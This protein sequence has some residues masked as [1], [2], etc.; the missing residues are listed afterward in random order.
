MNCKV[1]GKSQFLYDLK[2]E[3]DEE[4]PEA[5]SIKVCGSCWDVIAN[6]ANRAVAQKLAE[7]DDRISQIESDKEFA[8][9]VALYTPAA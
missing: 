7:L 4:I 1:C 6:I 2:F 9:T 3:A 5:Y 8:E